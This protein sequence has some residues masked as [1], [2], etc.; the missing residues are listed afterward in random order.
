MPPRASWMYM[1]DYYTFFFISYFV[2]I[3]N[4]TTPFLH[5]WGLLDSCFAWVFAF[6]GTAGSVLQ[7]RGRRFEQRRI[8]RTRSLGS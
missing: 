1:Y 4:E 2:G 8:R 6:V 7:Y 5:T 3:M